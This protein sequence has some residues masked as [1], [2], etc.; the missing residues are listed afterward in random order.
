MRTIAI[1]LALLVGFLLICGCIQSGETVKPSE[2]AQPTVQQT[3]ATSQQSPST[4][5]ALSNTPK[6]RP[7]DIIDDAPTDDGPCWLVISYDQDTDEYE[8][9]VVFMHDD[10]SWGY[11]LGEDTD[12]DERDFIEEYYPVLIAHVDLSDIDIEYIE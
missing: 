2:V 9:A 12:W 1:V 7:G 4:A 11:L 3:T 5:L 8:T 10:G 6:Y